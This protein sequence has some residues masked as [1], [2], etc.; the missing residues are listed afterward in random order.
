MLILLPL[1]IPIKPP[2][3]TAARII[4]AQFLIDCIDALDI[5]L[6]QLKIAFEIRLDTRLGLALRNDRMAH[7]DAPSQRNLGP[8]F[9]VL[10]PD[11]DKHGVVHQFSEVGSAVVDLVLVAEG[12][13]LGHVDAFLLVELS[14]G[15]LLE[16]GMQF[17]LMCGWDLGG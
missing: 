8:G 11:I 16:P 5:L 7:C 15:G 2:L 4:K 17:H 9:A 12:R 6:R 3:K 14:E 1:Q 13:V 10:L